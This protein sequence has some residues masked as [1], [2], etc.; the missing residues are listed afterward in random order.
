MCVGYNRV[1]PTYY[2]TSCITFHVSAAS[3]TQISSASGHCNLACPHI[4]NRILE[5]GFLSF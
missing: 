1:T 4:D 3:L 2:Y 5:K